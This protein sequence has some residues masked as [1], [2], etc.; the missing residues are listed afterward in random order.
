MA[1][2]VEDCRALDVNELNR[3]GCLE[4]PG[5]GRS[6]WIR[7]DGG[8]ETAS[9]G[10]RY[11]PGEPDVLELFYTVTPTG[12]RDGDPRDVEYEVP[13]EWT[14]CTY[15]GARPWFRCPECDTRRGK[16]YKHSGGGDRFL[17]R[18]CLDLIYESQTH[19]SGLVE[20]H[21]RLQ[22]VTDRLEDGY[23]TRAALR[24]LYDAKRAVFQ[25]HNALLEGWGRPPAFTRELP[26]FEVWA[27]RVIHRAI[28]SG[29]RPYGRLGRCT[30][31]AKTTGERCRQPAIGE[32][33]KCYYHGGA[34]G[35]G[36]GEGQT[37][38]RAERLEQFLD[39]DRSL[40]RR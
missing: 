8:E 5:V 2:T 12:Y 28:G 4:G 7:E 13:I 35:S 6:S 3:E 16:L 27:D 1:T 26:P 18:E 19:T 17:C 20:A 37:D 10:W 11:R 39:G 33:G 32:H 24:E 40:N 25:E 14:E 36:I 15:G 38:R 9:V 22:S 23:P 30:A 34:R 29:I 21:R 31:T